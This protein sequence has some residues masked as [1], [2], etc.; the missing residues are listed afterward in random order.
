MLAHSS[1]SLAQRILNP[2]R[3]RP[4]ANPPMPLNKHPAVSRSSRSLICSALR[5]RPACRLIVYSLAAGCPAASAFKVAPLVLVTLIGV[6]L[7]S[8][9]A[10]GDHFQSAISCPAVPSTVGLE[11]NIVNPIITQSISTRTGSRP[12]LFEAATLVP[13][14][15]GKTR[16]F[17]SSIVIWTTW[18]SLCTLSLGL[19]RPTW[20]PSTIG[21][22][23]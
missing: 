22:A 9:Y 12:Y 14:T 23:L 19:P 5:R 21:R 4:D 3:W 11:C 1:L 16:F 20:T 7:G 13:L 8:L 6:G 10:D 18:M 2:A 17:T 15:V